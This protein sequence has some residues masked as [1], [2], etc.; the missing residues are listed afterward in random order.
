MRAH[1]LLL[2]TDS[3]T[4]RTVV[5]EALNAEAIHRYEITAA[6]RLSAALPRLGVGQV[7]V[8]V[9]DLELPDSRG[10]A[11]F[12]AVKATGTEAALVVLRGAEDPPLAMRLIDAGAD[13]VLTAGA[14][15]DAGA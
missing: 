12:D 1:R 10:E 4:A 14:S 15:G 6:P 7:D 11:T 2:V 9:L 5:E 3:P 13:D 8:V